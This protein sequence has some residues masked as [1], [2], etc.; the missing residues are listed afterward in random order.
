MGNSMNIRKRILYFLISLCLISGQT[1]I[2][3]FAT[4]G[5]S[6]T[7]GAV[8]GEDAG[9][10]GGTQDA[11]GDEGSQGGG[12]TDVDG[13]S[14]G[15]DVNGSD[16]SSTAPDANAGESAK[17]PADAPEDDDI[18]E[19]ADDAGT[20]GDGT[21]DVEG[22]LSLLA[23]PLATP[24]DGVYTIVSTLATNKLFDIICGSA[25]NKAALQ[26]Y[27]ANHTPAQRF[28][29][30]PVSGDP[31]YYTIINVNSGKALDVPGANAQSKTTVQQYDANGTDAQ[32]W[33]F[34]STGAADGS[35]YIVSKLNPQLCLDVTGASTADGAR[36]QLHSANK[37]SAQK[38]LLQG[39]G[40]VITNG[41]YTIQSKLPS[42][43]ALDVPGGSLLSGTN[44]QIYE[45][46][47]SFA[48]KF[49][50]QFDANTGYYTIT[51]SM[52]KKTLDVAGANA[53]AGTNVIFHTPNGTN[54]QKWDIKPDGKGAYVLY[55]A[56]SGLALDVTAASANNG[57]NVQTYTPNGTSAQSWTFAA[58]SLLNDG[59]Y[60]IKS[61]LGT[62]LDVASN[63]LVAGTNIQAYKS[64][65]TLA[66]R[67]KVMHRADGYY[68]I[69]CLNSGLFVT[70][71]AS[72]GNVQLG[73]AVVNGSNLWR[74]LI[75][76]GGYVS[77][78]NKATGKVLDIQSGSSASGANVQVYAANGTTA[79]KWELVATSALPD[80]YYTIASAQNSDLVVDIP[81]ASRENGTKPQLYSSNDTAA[82]RFGIAASADGSYVITAM[83]STKNFD[84]A[85]AAISKSGS[86]VLQQYTPNNT[87]A[88][89]WRIEYAGNGQF[90]LYSLIK[91][92][93]CITVQGAVVETAPLAVSAYTGAATQRFT[94]R[95]VSN[96]SYIPYGITLN[97]MVTYQKTGNPFIASV[98]VAEIR[99]ALDPAQI[100][101]SAS[102]QFADLRSYSGLN[103]MQINGYLNSTPSGRTG[104]LRNYGAAF[105]SASQQYGIN[106]C[107]LVA[108]AI[109]ETG[110]GTSQ[111]ATGYHYD[112]KTAI[113]GSFYPAGTYYNFFGIGAYDT[114]PLAGGRSMAV[115]NGW[116]TPEKA[117]AGG[118]AWIAKYYLYASPYPQPTAYDMKWDVARSNVIRAYGW[119]QYATD[120][121]WSTKNSNLM[122][123][124]YEFSGF[125]PKLHYLIPT[126]AL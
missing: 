23:E 64:N 55:A 119:H 77:F 50:V 11:R 89:K 57:T 49:S 10:A 114:S 37:T 12:H 92:S 9:D 81:C 76:G 40:G 39:Q 30:K 91:S 88:Q 110:W 62:V 126:Y 80:G 17:D 5:V 19:S 118:A 15:T 73:N 56:C 32:K 52:S 4:E 27:T 68:T 22:N 29:V 38:F 101:G 103:A 6:N 16:D 82:Q 104:I 48:Q 99:N 51:G 108:H 34:V 60:Q 94:L 20:D 47:G 75:G 121:L 45:G 35:Y 58:T 109:N 7:T 36:V 122:S 65:G 125:T 90:I 41:L 13:S 79:Q 86:G 26:M 107:F 105:V 74:P 54:A 93:S 87:N 69:E 25:D 66:Q 44:A 46:N 111:L 120:H 61:A 106:E 97:Q 18:V 67:F 83:C 2:V 53:T 63:G 115:K 43:P 96:T 78:E 113:E 84:I 8:A 24:I 33:G 14:A 21:S 116:N 28:R 123:K 72:T 59:V 112:G 71:A 1:G 70:C 95:P 100:N 3:A 31:G 42:S 124:C 98:S 102:Y 117:I 85:S